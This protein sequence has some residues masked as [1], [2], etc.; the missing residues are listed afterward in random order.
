MHQVYFGIAKNTGHC[1][2]CGGTVTAA[3][4]HTHSCGR[5]PSSGAE[6]R[7]FPL[8]HGRKPLAGPQRSA[9]AAA[10][11]EQGRSS[12]KLVEQVMQARALLQ[13]V[14]AQ[15]DTKWWPF[16]GGAPEPVGS[17]S[18]RPLDSLLS[19]SSAQFRASDSQCGWR[20]TNSSSGHRASTSGSAGSS[21]PSRPPSEL[22]SGG[23]LQRMLPYFDVLWTQH[24]AKWTSFLEAP[25]P[26]IAY[27]D[28]PWPD[29]DAPNDLLL[30]K[31]QGGPT[32]QSEVG[33]TIRQLTLQWHPDKFQQRFGS[34]LGEDDRDRIMGRVTAIFQLVLAHKTGAQE[35][36]RTAP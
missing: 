3:E 10:S 26:Q 7:G 35:R 36:G 31:L 16:S 2:R 33:E 4:R 19:S 18:A 17:G 21:R 28:V 13:P 11:R 20:N 29:V 15:L 34:R 30:L 14:D 9:P 6:G 22:R 27:S 8:R 1:L 32:G 25:L 5:P 24:Q 12:K 23:R